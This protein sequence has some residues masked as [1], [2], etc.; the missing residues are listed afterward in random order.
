MKENEFKYKKCTVCHLVYNV[1][2]KDKQEHYLCPICQAKA[3]KG[4]VS[5]ALLKNKNR[6][7]KG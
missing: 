5:K 2:I 7:L 1:S 4:I 3:N 6:V